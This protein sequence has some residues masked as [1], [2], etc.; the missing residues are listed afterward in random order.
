M[1]GELVVKVS[2]LKKEYSSVSQKIIALK[3]I[4]I[5]IKKRKDYLPKFNRMF[6]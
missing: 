2:K 6:R 3:E 4:D 5:E 1:M